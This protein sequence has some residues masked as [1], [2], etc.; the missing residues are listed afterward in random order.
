MLVY[1]DVIGIERIIASSGQSVDLILDLSPLIAVDHKVCSR[2]LSSII[3]KAF[4]CDHGV[5]DPDDPQI[6]SLYLCLVHEPPT[7]IGTSHMVKFLD[8]VSA[9]G[10]VTCHPSF[11]LFLSLSLYITIAVSY[12][13]KKTALHSTVFSSLP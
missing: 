5:M 6:D 7:G 9:Y 1:I 11:L 3:E 13:S 2:E 4:L 10:A 12:L 8:Q